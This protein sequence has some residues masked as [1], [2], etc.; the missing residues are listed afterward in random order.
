M[1]T[2]NKEK[3]L[4][5]DELAIKVLE[6]DALIQ[7]DL[8]LKIF[9]QN[10]N[11]LSYMITGLFENEEKYV[12]LNKK[13]S[14]APELILMDSNENE[15]KI[16]LTKEFTKK[17]KADLEHV[18]KAYLGYKYYIKEKKTIKERLKNI[19]KDFK[20]SPI[21]YFLIIAATIS[22]FGFYLLNR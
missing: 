8:S 21:P 18:E 6:N 16:K 13:N 20:E 5:E 11:L 3:I 10:E 1:N 14:K 22:Y 7:E 15:V 2:E 4:S 17:L 19:P 9:K 12:S